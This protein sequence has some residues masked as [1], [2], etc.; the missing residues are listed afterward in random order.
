LTEVEVIPAL[1]ETFRSFLRAKYKRKLQDLTLYMQDD[2]VLEVD[3]GEFHDSMRYWCKKL[4]DDPISILKEL[5][6]IA[7]KEMIVGEDKKE[8]VKLIK[9]RFVNVFDRKKIIRSLRSNDI[10][11]FIS[12]EGMVRK[13]TDTKPEVINAMFKCSGCGRFVTVL[14]ELGN[15]KTPNDPCIYCQSRKYEIIPT[16]CTYKDI[17]KI[18]I[19]EFPEG[20]KGGEQPHLIEVKL[21]DDLVSKVTAGSRCIINGILVP[22]QK[23]KGNLVFDMYIDANNIEKGDGD[24]SE[25]KITEDDETEILNLSKRPTIISDIVGSIAPAIYGYDEIKEAMAMSMF[26]GV[27]K[28]LP[29][30]SIVRGDSHILLVGDPSVAKSQLLKYIVRLSPRG[31]YTS[32]KSSTSAGLTATAIQD[33]DGRWTLEAGALVLADLGIAAIDEMDKMRAEDRSALHEAMEQQSISVAKA[34][35]TATLQCRCSLIGAA[36]PKLGRFDECEDLHS[37]ID[38]PPSLLSRFDLIFVIRDISDADMDSRVGDHILEIHSYGEK[39]F[40]GGTLD[41]SVIEPKISTELFR[42]YIAY[43]KIHVNPVMNKEVI[44]ILKDTYMDFRARSSPTQG[45][46]ITPRQL[47]ALIRLSEASA[48]MRLS[49]SIEKQDVERALRIFTYSMK[50][51][52]YDKETNT[53]DID[54]IVSPVSTKQRDLMHQILSIIR[55][56]GG[57]TKTSIIVGKLTGHGKTDV[58]I[59]DH[60]EKMKRE[61]LLI[62]PINGMVKEI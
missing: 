57:K 30:G 21:Q 41:Y 23:R 44:T 1:E 42:K 7:R 24:Y 56:E 50:Q 16:R 31:I 45:I 13:V 43:A 6:E 19:Q 49:N 47:E 60:I 38:M 32:G 46:S 39:L 40:N 62:E 36:N 34:G 28:I 18:V 61:G 20:L 58:Q 10:G 59:Y 27:R 51:V 9:V 55:E 35:I 48:R 25:I 33:T 5:D 29:D 14:Q 22:I 3:Y 54:K 12:I 2:P 8:Y 15:L 37:Q 11:S 4:K 52:M 26:G 17:Q 53:F